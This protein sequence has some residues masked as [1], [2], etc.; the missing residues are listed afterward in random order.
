MS[1]KSVEES[2]LRR[3]SASIPQE[4]NKNR[5]LFLLIVICLILI[6]VLCSTRMSMNK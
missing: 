6:G 2:I 5:L 4:R 3:E 1:E